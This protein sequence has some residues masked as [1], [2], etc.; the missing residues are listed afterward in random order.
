[1]S[2]RAAYRPIA[3]SA[4]IIDSPSQSEPRSLVTGGCS[5]AP[6]FSDD[7]ATCEP[8]EFAVLQQ[9]YDGACRMLGIRAAPPV[10]DDNKGL[11]KELV[12][13]LLCA[14]RLGEHDHVALTAAAIFAGKRYRHA[15]KR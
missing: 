3:S 10:A 6:Y 8:E 13:A 7:D 11:R 5:L 15:P 4:G 2:R 12:D 1:M 14:V 9:A